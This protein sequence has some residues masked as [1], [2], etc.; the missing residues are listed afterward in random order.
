MT[1]QGRLSPGSMLVATVVKLSLD[2]QSTMSTVAWFSLFMCCYGNCCSY[3]VL[4]SKL[5][6]KWSSTGVK[7]SDDYTD[8]LLTVLT[9]LNVCKMLFDCSLNCSRNY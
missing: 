2:V 6:E 4:S 5:P 7:L 1:A 9:G 3:H 8:L